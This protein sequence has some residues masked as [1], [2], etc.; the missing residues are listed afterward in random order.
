MKV[1]VT[2]ASG[3]I[4]QKL[5]QALEGEGHDVAVLSRNPGRS[6][7][8]RVRAVAGDLLGDR[9][10]LV[11][12][13]EGCDV[14]FHCAGEVRD[15]SR[16]RALHVDGTRGLLDAARAQSV[17]SGKPIHWVQLSSVGAYGP[18]PGA[19]HDERVV[20]EETPP[21]PVGEYEITKTLAD[22][23][24]MQA[25]AMGAITFSLVRP[26]NV[27]GATMPNN[28]LRALGEMVRR[29]LFFYIG[30]PG[31]VATYVHVDDVVATLLACGT[32]V[33]ARGQIFNLSND[34]L[35]E[36]LIGG[37]AAAL[38]VRA[39]TA[40]VPEFLV[41]GVQRVAGRLVRLPLTRERIDNLVLRTR[42]PF[43]KLQ[44]QLGIAPRVAVPKAIG[45]VLVQPP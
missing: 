20:S 34:C 4:G 22:E 12:L 32:D 42:Y 9:S 37:M 36:E 18:P 11:R 6:F 27:F 33:R 39:P 29:G 19:A 1:A 16:M 38:G 10:A 2:G 25:G 28:S 30:P 13:L 8:P 35:L 21:R 31:A 24:I 5:L 14:I 23:L 45:E 41:R 15:Q 17:T 44:G 26:S 40:R 3:F 43:A 7:P